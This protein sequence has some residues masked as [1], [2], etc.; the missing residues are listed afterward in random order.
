MSRDGG[1]A[2]Q[3]DKTA[4]FTSPLNTKQQQRSTAR[5]TSRRGAA[6]DSGMKSGKQKRLPGR[7][8]RGSIRRFIYIVKTLL[9]TPGVA[10]WQC[11]N[12]SDVETGHRSRLP[13]NKNHS[14]SPGLARCGEA[15]LREKCHNRRYDLA[16][17]RIA[18]CGVYAGRSREFGGGRRH[19]A[20]VSHLD[21]HRADRA[22][23]QRD[24]ARSPCGP[25]S[26][27]VCGATAKRSGRRGP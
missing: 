4:S 26:L 6:R 23:R 7:S 1:G 16:T 2:E 12:N 3:D 8:Y 21:R 5:E 13:S 10:S 25:A 20:D 11:P 18:V 22:H 19:A 9:I 24:Q 27:A 15:D 14:H 17:I